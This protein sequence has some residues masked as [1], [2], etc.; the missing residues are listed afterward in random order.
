[1]IEASASDAIR[2]AMFSTLISWVMRWMKASRSTSPTSPSRIA[3]LTA[4]EGTKAAADSSSS[5]TA[6]STSRQYAKMPTK[7]LAR[8]W[9]TR[10]PRKLRIARGVNWLE[11]SCDVTTVI[12]NAR[13][14][15]VM[16]DP[17]TVERMLRAAEA[18]PSKTIPIPSVPKPRSSSTSATASPTN[19]S[20][21]SPG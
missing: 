20:A 5:R 15:T 21:T 18:S 10:S 7:A 11:T 3:R 6:R 16:S 1:L 9:L 14:A 2:G 17:A 12:E 8:S 19:A 13:P 4:R